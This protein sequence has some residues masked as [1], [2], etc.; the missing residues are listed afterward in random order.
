MFDDDFSSRFEL[1]NYISSV[2]E[3]LQIVG[4]KSRRSVISKVCDVIIKTV[5]L[6]LYC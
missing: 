5:M 2:F 4:D 1:Y 6:L 3:V